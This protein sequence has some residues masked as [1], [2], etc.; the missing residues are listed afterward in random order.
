MQ[1]TLEREWILLESLAD[2]HDSRS[3]ELLLS[4]AFPLTAESI[5]GTLPSDGDGAGKLICSE[6]SSKECSQRW[7][8]SVFHES[9]VEVS[10]GSRAD[11][12]KE[13]KVDYERNNELT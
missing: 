10:D 6:E 13:E 12:L 9:R 8:E 3:V 1:R 4:A 2:S 11:W 5:L 7:I